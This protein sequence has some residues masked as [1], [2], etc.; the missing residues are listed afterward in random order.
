MAKVEP[1]HQFYSKS[2]ENDNLF[3]KT[4]FGDQKN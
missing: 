2:T 4:K 1:A 3:T